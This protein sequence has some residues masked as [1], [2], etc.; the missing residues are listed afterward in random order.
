MAVTLEEEAKAAQVVAKSRREARV[1][2]GRLKDSINQ[3]VQR[4]VI[5]FREYFYGAYPEKNGRRNSTLEENAKMM[6]GDVPYKIERLDEDGNSILE[7]NKATSGRV[8]T[9]ERKK[10]IEKEQDTTRALL[11][12][13]RKR[14]A[15]A[16][17]DD[18][19]E[20]N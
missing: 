2:T 13:R 8:A 18:T 14:N 15:E 4:G 20:D 12:E 6:M 11:I 9:Y 16:E 17:K 7:V 10:R 1:D 3:K 5:V 19:S